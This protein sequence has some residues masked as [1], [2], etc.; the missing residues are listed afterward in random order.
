MDFS[1]W[2]FNWEWDGSIYGEPP[3]WL[4]RAGAAAGALGAA[5]WIAGWTSGR[6]DGA[7]MGLFVAALALGLALSWTLAFEHRTA[8]VVLG[9]LALACGA[10][11]LAARTEWAGA[12]ALASRG[13]IVLALGLPLLTRI[14]GAT[15]FS[16]SLD[17]DGAALD[18]RAVRAE[19][20]EGT[21]L[22]LRLEE[23]NDGDGPMRARVLRGEAGEEVVVARALLGRWGERATRPKGDGLHVL[24]DG[25]VFGE[26]RVADDRSYRGGEPLRAIESATGVDLVFWRRRTYT[27]RGEIAAGMFVLALF[28]AAA[29]AVVWLV[30][31]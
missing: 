3:P 31:R 11:A 9:N 8:V 26:R 4:V 18:A 2:W 23:G 5:A 24:V 19:A 10:S 6:V 30:S 25:A 17:H 15:S 7:S 20:G 12:I 21:E 22:L 16:I 29:G 14:W 28:H 1:G 13:P 27:F